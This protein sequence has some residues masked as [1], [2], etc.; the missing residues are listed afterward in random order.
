MEFQSGLSFVRLVGGRACVLVRVCPSAVCS[1]YRVQS[2]CGVANGVSTADTAYYQVAMV[3][4]LARWVGE[5]HVSGDADRFASPEALFMRFGLRVFGRVGNN[6]GGVIYCLRAL[7]Y[8]AQ[9]IRDPYASDRPSNLEVSRAKSTGPWPVQVVCQT[10]FRVYR[11]ICQVVVRFVISICSCGYDFVFYCIFG[12][13]QLGRL[14]RV[15]GVTRDRFVAF[16]GF[17]D[18]TRGE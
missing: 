12:R 4:S 11:F 8:V 2:N 14:S 5:L 15:A 3:P 18:G 16:V 10:I 9:R 17:R 1:Q 13:V 7:R 6:F